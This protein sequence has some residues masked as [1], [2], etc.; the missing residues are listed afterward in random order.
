MI[1]TNAVL[2]LTVFST[3]EFMVIFVLHSSKQTGQL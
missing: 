3:S 2:G 1:K